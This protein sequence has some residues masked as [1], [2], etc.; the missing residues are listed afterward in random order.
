MPG[1]TIL[2]KGTGNGVITDIDGNY[3]INVSGSNS[4]LVFSF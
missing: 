3:T 1:L 2:E 4:I